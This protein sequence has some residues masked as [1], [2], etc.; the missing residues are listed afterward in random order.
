MKEYQRD[1]RP[2]HVIQSA[3]AEHSV[4]AGHQILFDKTT[5]IAND[6]IFSEE[7][8]GFENTETFRQFEQRLKLK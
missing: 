8:R 5:T 1:V 4:E 2:K 6:I 7:Q 3:L